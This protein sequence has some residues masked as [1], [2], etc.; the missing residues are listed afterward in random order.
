MIESK[1]LMINGYHGIFYLAGEFIF[2]YASDKLRVDVIGFD[3][4]HI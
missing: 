1:D 2:L 4:L 3:V